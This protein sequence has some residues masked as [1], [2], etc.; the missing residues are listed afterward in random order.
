MSIETK[1]P[2]EGP[3]AQTRLLMG[4][5]PDFLA[6]LAQPAQIWAVISMEVLGALWAA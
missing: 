3:P 4:E 6:A 5:F 1:D 2:K